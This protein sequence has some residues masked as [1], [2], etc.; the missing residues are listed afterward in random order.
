MN[1]VTRQLVNKLAFTKTRIETTTQ[2]A[3]SAEQCRLRIEPL[4][5]TAKNIVYAN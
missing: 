5:L 2:R 3:L 4:G 1:V